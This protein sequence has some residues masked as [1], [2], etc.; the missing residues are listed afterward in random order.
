MV[1]D[2]IIEWVIRDDMPQVLE[3][4]NRSF[5]HPWKV[6]E[7][8]RLLKKRNCIA[9]AAKDEER[10]VVYGYMLHRL[11]KRYIMLER[12]AV[13]PAM[14][15]HGVGT[16]LIDKLKRKLSRDRRNRLGLLVHEAD[17][18]AQLFFKAM[19]FRGVGIRKRYYGESDAYAMR[20]RVVEPSV[21]IGIGGE[22]FVGE[23]DV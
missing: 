4:E 18:G 17:L 2:M 20:Y 23:Q 3:I 13:A 5:H 9:L 19:G 22:D 11:S 1:D 10:G 21:P 16:A 8:V 7:F 14:R 15:R 6:D 12:M